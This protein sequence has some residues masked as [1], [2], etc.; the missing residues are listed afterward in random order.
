MELE[1]IEEC[2]LWQGGVLDTNINGVVIC[3]NGGVSEVCTIQNPP[4]S[5]ANF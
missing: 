3:N 4:Q 1:R 5:I 2:C